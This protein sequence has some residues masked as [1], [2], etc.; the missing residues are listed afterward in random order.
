MVVFEGGGHGEDV[1]VGV[2]H[3]GGGCEVAGRDGLLELF[4]EAGFDDGD[5]ASVDAVDV[6]RVDVNAGDF[7]AVVGHDDGGG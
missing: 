7:E 2:D 5:F 1:Y 6:G 3:V 4:F